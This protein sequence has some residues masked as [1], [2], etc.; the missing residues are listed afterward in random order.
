[1]SCDLRVIYLYTQDGYVFRLRIHYPRELVALDNAA[2]S[3]ETQSDVTRIKAESAVMRRL[4]VSLPILTST[5]YG[6]VCEREKGERERERERE[7][8]LAQ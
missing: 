8:I 5:L 1:M 3:S 7:S 4:L 2:S 6:R